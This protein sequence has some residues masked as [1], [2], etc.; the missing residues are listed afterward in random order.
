MP[1]NKNNLNNGGHLEFEEKVADLD[2]QMNELRR[3]S[4]IKGID[5]SAEIR[6]LQRQQ[7]TELKRIYSNLTAWQTVQVARHPNRPLLSDYLSLMVKDFRELH[8]DK[9]FGDDRAIVTGFGQIGRERVLIVGQNK[10]KTTKQKIA[11]NFGSP[12]PEGYR[13]AIAKMKLAE[14]FSIPIVTLI[15]TP[16][17][18]PGIGAEERGQAQAIAFNLHKMSRLKVPVICIV[19]GE[20]GSGGALG[21]G[22]GDRLAILEFAYYSVI[23]PEG[24]AAILWRDGSQAPKAAEALKLTSKDLH[25]LGLVDSVISEPLGGAHRNLHD[26]VYNVERYIVKTLRDLKRTKLDNLLDNRYKKL[27]SIGISAKEKLHRKTQA[28]K[29]RVKEALED[30]PSKRKPIPAK[31]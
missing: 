18:Y 23:S 9:C 24:C 8:G 7:V 22:V 28:G 26:T 16:G 3:L 10:G 21:I 2:S 5:Y 15:D 17:A 12:N 25:K 6:R 11:C 27:R 20:G 31:I 4:S 30:I 13:K 29:E 1:N 19:I 14:K